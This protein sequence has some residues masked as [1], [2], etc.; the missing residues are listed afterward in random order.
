MFNIE[1]IDTPGRTTQR[2]AFWTSRQIYLLAH[3]YL[4]FGLKF[5]IM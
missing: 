4:A 1:W 2:T 3:F 5:R